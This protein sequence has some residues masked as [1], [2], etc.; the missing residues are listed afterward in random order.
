MVR[1]AVDGPA[2]GCVPVKDRSRPRRASIAVTRGPAQR[3]PRV[4]KGTFV[5]RASAAAPQ[6]A[7]PAVAPVS[8]RAGEPLT[9]MTSTT[10][11]VGAPAVPAA[12]VPDRSATDVGHRP[13]ARPAVP[14][15]PGG[16]AA[17]A[18]GRRDGLGRRWPPAGGLFTG[19]RP[20]HGRSPRHPPSLD[21][22]G[23][24]RLAV[25][26]CPSEPAAGGRPCTS[27]GRRSVDGRRPTARA[28]GDHACA[29]RHVDRSRPRQPRFGRR[30]RPMA[31]SLVAACAA[32]VPWLGLGS[33]APGGRIFSSDPAL[34]EHRTRGNGSTPPTWA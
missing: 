8:S 25:R 17:R 19:G 6:S 7:R 22:R 12:R 3:A 15:P 32:W 30:G 14:C 4:G 18:V 2:P 26:G 5:S 29:G 1:S 9:R 16:R 31:D 10:G 34:A 33:A 23:S 28:R 11:P 13:C 21:P 27:V 20:A 24:G